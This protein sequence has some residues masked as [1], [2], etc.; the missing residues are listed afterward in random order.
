MELIGTHYDTGA[1]ISLRT[2]AGRISEI[3]ELS[4][5]DL[6]SSDR[7]DLVIAPGFV[8]LQINGCSGIE[9]VDAHLTVEQVSSVCRA[10]DRFGVTGLCPTVTTHHFDMMRRSLTTIAKACD[11]V[12][13][14]AQRVLG[15][16]MEGPYI[17]V[18]DGPRG[19]HPREH[20]RPYDWD[21]FRRL[22]DAAD[23]RIIILTLSPEYE[24]AAEFI[25]QVTGS[26]VT[27]AIGHTAASTDQIQA[28]VD[29][30][31]TL[32]THL[33]NGAHGQIRRHPNYIWDQLAEDRLTASLIV[34]GHH[35]PPNVVKSFVRCKT[36]DRCI[37]V[38]DMTGMAGMP[39]GR[40]EKSSLG[41]IEVLEDGRLVVA[42]QRQYLAGASQPITVGISNML[43][44]ADL[45]I[46]QA[47]S[48]ASTR[49]ARLIGR[50]DHRLREGCPANLVVFR[51]TGSD[52]PSEKGLS[53][54]NSTP[55]Q[56]EVMETVV[57]GQVVYSG[58][59]L[60]R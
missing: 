51:C 59:P 50:S 33:G 55:Q 45:T 28:A 2:Q 13:D 20:C 3:R 47:V 44:F 30:G 10:Q 8:D 29:A 43:Q 53:S 4:L 15:V 41:D 38:S 37:L 26:G 36:L 21:E 56:I 9:F 18:E 58:P 60:D 48:M 23:G 1:P 32:S 27:V 46:T 5:D 6:A 42:E 7:N 25:R 22:Q 14:V 17:S 57:C 11:S 31:A 16:H 34:D 39:P 54:S 49:P 40:Y 12:E 19:A 35:L 24:F 52:A